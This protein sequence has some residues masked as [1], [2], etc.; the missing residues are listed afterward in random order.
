V[1]T[2]LL[3]LSLSACSTNSDLPQDRADRFNG[4]VVFNIG[5]PD[6]A[7]P[8][9]QTLVHQLCDGR[10]YDLTPVGFQIM[11]DTTAHTALAQADPRFPGGNG[12]LTFQDKPINT[13]GAVKLQIVSNDPAITNLTMDTA[14]DIRQ[15]Q[16]AINTPGI[17][18]PVHWKISFSQSGTART[19]E[20][21]QLLRGVDF[22]SI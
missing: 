2:C 16:N 11:P 9:L 19:L 3:A 20:A 6:G 1:L 15:A 17:S 13:V 7:T 21:D 18:F 8:E 22:R 4:A 14:F 12:R 5:G 10:D